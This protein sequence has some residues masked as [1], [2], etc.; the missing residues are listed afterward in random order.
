MYKRVQG[1]SEYIINLTIYFSHFLVNIQY[2]G[3][4]SIESLE[5]MSRRHDVEGGG[6]GINCQQ[7]II[8]KAE[9]GVGDCGT[10]LSVLKEILPLK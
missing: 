9:S 4:R 6:G 10:R 5:A 8:I 7:N 1:G 3:R 2:Q